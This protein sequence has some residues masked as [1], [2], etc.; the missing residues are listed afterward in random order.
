[1]LEV[2]LRPSF[3]PSGGEGRVWDTGERGD[4]G[5]SP[6]QE[7]EKEGKALKLMKAWVEE[8]VE[9]LK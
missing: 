5:L 6:L 1:M 8:A 2:M 7:E 9:C 4:F 3:P